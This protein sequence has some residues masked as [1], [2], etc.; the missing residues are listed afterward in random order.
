MKYSFL[1]KSCLLAT[2]LGVSTA[3]VAMSQQFPTVV[4]NDHRIHYFKYDPNE[5]FHIKTKVGYSTLIQLSSGETIT[6]DGGLGMGESKSWSV[7]VK[8]NNI[9]FKPVESVPETNM[10]LVTNKRTY[11]FNL[12]TTLGNDMTY[13]ARF[14]YP[15]QGQ[16]PLSTSSATYPSSNTPA[17]KTFREVAKDTYIDSRINTS[18]KSKGDKIVPTNVWDNGMFTYLRFNNTNEL[19]AVYKV[20]QDG[21]EVLVNSHVE[22][23]LLIVHEVTQLLRLRL[24]NA[25]ADIKNMKNI[26]TGFNHQATSQDGLERVVIQ[27]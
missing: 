3:Q 11:A 14:I 26:P 18:Y 7:A 20:M 1:L 25:V 23:D 4:G 21:N 15:E 9:F 27:Q 10:I 8:S 19:P 2:L 16:V 12:S 5:I 6:D 22:K 17:P 13:I 24:G